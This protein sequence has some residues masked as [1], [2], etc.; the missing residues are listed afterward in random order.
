MIL[1]YILTFINF[2]GLIVLGVYVVY[3][4][5]LNQNAATLTPS[6]SVSLLSPFS[7]AEECGVDFPDDSK[8]TE[9]KSQ[10]DQD[11]VFWR[12][13]RLNG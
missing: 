10:F 9:V 11:E 5:R 3:S 4:R 13:E 12:R 2:I 7:T 8:M 1:L 6:S